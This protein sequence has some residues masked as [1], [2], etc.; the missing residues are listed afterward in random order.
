MMKRMAHIVLLLC[1]VAVSTSAQTFTTL[2]NFD[3]IDGADPGNGFLAQG[4][5]GNLYG[6]TFTS[7]E[8]SYGGAG[9]AFEITTAGSLTVV[10][11][12]CSQPN[13]ADGSLLFSNLIQATDENLYGT[14]NEGG[15][16]GKG[17]VF[18]LTPGGALTTIYSFC[19]Q[20]SCSDGE[21]PEAQLLEAADGSFYGGTFSGGAHQ[22]GTIFR[23]TPEGVLTTLY[24]FCSLPGCAD[25][26]SPIAGLIQ[27]RDGNLYGTT[28]YCGGYVCGTVFKITPSGTFTTLSSN[29]GGAPYSS[30]TEVASGDFYGTTLDGGPG[31]LGTA[32]KITPGGAVTTL[33]NFDGADGSEPLGLI[34][35]TDGNFYG[36]TIG[37][38]NSNCD[39]GAGCGTIFK[40]SAS[41]TV[42]T[43]EKFDGF[44]GAFP[45][46]G[47]I[48]ATD[49]NLYG[50]TEGG[51]GGFSTEYG[52]V[53]KLLTGLAPF[54]QTLPT[55]R[56]VG[57]HVV[58]LGNNLTGSTAVSFNGTAAPFTVVSDTEITA[59]VP[60]SATSGFVTVTTAS[61]ALKSNK[62]FQ[63]VP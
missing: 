1:A 27:G 3:L 16:N 15:A 32:F 9:V 46:A 17:T 51:L 13:C 24:S 40:M 2:A 28:Y 42:T 34:Q 30:L 12:F 20:P 31:N 53:F 8:T 57:G 54:V 38:G 50:T 6:T 56:E 11:A 47:L 55:S 43:L 22:Y 49:G 23:V 33:H 21:D 36:T 35:A 5:N 4:F 37:G 62:P 18:K 25:G 10:Y 41:G 59:T 45:V 29:V 61:G 14:T 26:D 63:I 52:T 60:S 44:N 19:S 39:Y 7:I 58:I 48:Q